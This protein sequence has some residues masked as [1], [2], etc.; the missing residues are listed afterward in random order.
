[1]S[2]QFK[3]PT[4]FTAFEKDDDIL[5]L[6]SNIAITGNGIDWSGNLEKDLPKAKRLVYCRVCHGPIDFHALLKGDLDAGWYPTFVEWSSILLAIVLFVSQSF[7]WWEVMGIAV[8]YGVASYLVL[9]KVEHLRL[10][11]HRLSPET[12]AQ[13]EAEKRRG[14]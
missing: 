5:I 1:M 7:E 9:R 2:R 3:C 10:A 4:C 6:T 13:L 11:R 12:V 14:N 8:G